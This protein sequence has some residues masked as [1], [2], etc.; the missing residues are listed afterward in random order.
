[1]QGSVPEGTVFAVFARSGDAEQYMQ[2]LGASGDEYQIA[3][4]YTLEE[5]QHFS[6]VF[7]P[8]FDH[9]TINPTNPQTTPPNLQPFGRLLE[10]ARQTA[11]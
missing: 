4:F 9:I 1:M 10:I 2:E 5:V 7:S 3:G 8:H 6:Q 11:E